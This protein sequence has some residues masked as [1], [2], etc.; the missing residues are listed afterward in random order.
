ML[1]VLLML[2][3]YLIAATRYTLFVNE[4][5]A[6]IL[7]SSNHNDKITLPFS[8]NKTEWFVNKTL[9]YI[10]GDA[11]IA[12]FQKK[13]SN[14][15]NTEG[16]CGSGFELWLHIYKVYEKRIIPL[17]IILVGSCK[18]SFSL[19]SLE[20]GNSDS[21]R[22]YSSFRWSNSGFSIEWFSKKNKNG[23][24]ISK[25]AYSIK[26]NNIRVEQTYVE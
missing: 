9:N 16:F 23:K 1:I 8:D 18:E 11:Y 19:A 2:P 25:T 15:K 7:D 26:N 4:S 20:S 6:Y 17:R 12:A 14:P 13:P 21:D 22:D 10:K 24:Y 5:E 3:G